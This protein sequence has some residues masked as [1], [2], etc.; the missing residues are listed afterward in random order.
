MHSRRQFSPVILKYAVGFGS[1]PKVMPMHWI[2]VVADELMKRGNEH[3]IASGTSISGVPHVGSAEDPILADAIARSVRARGGKAQAIWLRDDLDQLRKIPAQIPPEFEKYLGT[4]VASLPCPEGSHCE[5]FVEH[6]GGPFVASLRRAGVDIKVYSGAQ[7][8]GSGM[9][10]ELTLIAM[11]KAQQIRQIFSEVS[12]AEKGEDWMP[13]QAICEKCGKIGTTKVTG[14]SGGKFSYECAGGTADRKEIKGCGH[15][16]QCSPR[17]GKL[18]WRVEWAARWKILGITCEPF[19][20]DHAAAG[21]SWDTCSRIIKEIFDYPAPHPVVYEWV[22]VGGKRMKKSVG[23]VITFD[24]FVSCATAEVARFFFFRTKAWKHRDFDLGKNLLTLIDDYERSERI[25]FGKE[26]CQL[27]KELPDIRRTYELAQVKDVPKE[28]FQVQFG[29]LIPVVQIAQDWKGTM[30]ILRRTEGL[31][32]VTPEQEA[33]LQRKCDAVRFWLENWAPEDY[34][35][36]VKAEKPAVALE[37]AVVQFLHSAA[38]TL[39]AVPWEAGAIHSH[40]HDSI[41]ASGLEAKA[42]FSGFYQ[43]ILGQPRGPRLGYFLASLERDFV[44]K[45]LQEI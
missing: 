32:P 35:F 11:D 37:P 15:K 41:K 42:A 19:G 38:Q 17:S 28:F 1:N 12:G 30:E 23:L 10:D 4:P 25:Y 40:I 20:K 3:V 44:L 8:Y 7:M 31:G 22:V 45:R 43:A 9:Y 21:G 39:A 34:K 16:G 24:E 5:S 27:E 36:S 13:F 33:A 2:D 18:Q 29:H 14:Y 6:F 26:E